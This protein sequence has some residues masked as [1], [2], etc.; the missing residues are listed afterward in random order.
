MSDNLIGLR[1]TL[2]VINWLSHS[3]IFRGKKRNQHHQYRIKRVRKLALLGRRGLQTHFKGLRLA[4]LFFSPSSPQHPIVKHLRRPR[5]LSSTT[6]TSSKCQRPRERTLSAIDTAHTACCCCARVS[7][8]AQSLNERLWKKNL[9]RD[10]LLNLS[11][12]QPV[13]RYYRH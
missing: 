12:F 3:M 8:F 2:T 5:N 4:I 7:V 6:S 1:M 13:N 10:I 9:W 11:T